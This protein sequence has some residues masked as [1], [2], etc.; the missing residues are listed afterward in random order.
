MLA[1]T[2]AR[3]DRMYRV[4]RHIYDPTRKFY[5][6]GRDR[7]IERLR[8]KSGDHAV[9]IGCGTGRNLTALARRYP[10]TMLYGLDASAAMLATA[11]HKLRREGLA[12]RITLAAGLGEDLDPRAMFRLDR[13]FDAVVI[14]YALSMIPAWQAVVQRAAGHLRP[15]GTLA[16]VDFGDQHGLPGWFRGLLT[17]WLGL[18]GVEPRRDLPDVLARMT[19]ERGG[20]LSADRL[21]G[22]YAVHIVYTAPAQPG[23]F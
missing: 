20:T 4:Q 10:G 3:M 12:D 19:R 1:D 15:G 21:F 9:E 18:L 8:L 6:L 22:G 17:A 5:L 7:L 14:S 11:R 2:A 23:R 16:I 13:G